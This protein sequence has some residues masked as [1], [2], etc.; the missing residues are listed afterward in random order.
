MSEH[1]VSHARDG[2]AIVCRRER[3]ILVGDRPNRGRASQESF[4]SFL[5]QSALHADEEHDAEPLVSPLRK[6]APAR[7][8]RRLNNFLFNKQASVYS[9][10]APRTFD[11]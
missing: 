10:I 8:W 11:G 2:G 3:R 5:E 1:V 6:S 9:S 7:P 4:D